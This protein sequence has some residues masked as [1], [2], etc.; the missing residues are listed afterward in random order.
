MATEKKLEENTPEAKQ[1]MRENWPMMVE[2]LKKKDVQ[3]QFFDAGK[4]I[5]WNGVNAVERECDLPQSECPPRLL[6]YRGKPSD[7]K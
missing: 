7:G 4:Y 3:D 2:L 5:D 6:P 1:F